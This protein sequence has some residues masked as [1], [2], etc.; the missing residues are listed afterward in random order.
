MYKIEML[1]NV[2]MSGRGQ[3]KNEGMIIC[4]KPYFCFFITKPFS[5]YAIV[6]FCSDVRLNLSNAGS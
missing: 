4:L 1:G 2:L 6:R 3:E 5:L